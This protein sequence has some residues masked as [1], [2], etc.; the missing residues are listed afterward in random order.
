M[1]LGRTNTR[2]RKMRWRHLPPPLPFLALLW[3]VA[4][5]ARGDDFAPPRRV[6]DG[7]GKA[8]QAATGIDVANNAYIATVSDEKILVKIIGPD[9]DAQV[10]VA[11][12]GLG[13]GDPDF[14]TSSSGITHMTFSQIDAEAIDEG[15]EIWTT[16]NA[17]GGGVFTPPRRITKNRIDDYAPRL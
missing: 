10:P 16:T 4:E 5:P 12:Q 9:L 1:G 17:G 6:S 7:S 15:R 11:I 13:Q 8:T 2:R 3:V 14:A